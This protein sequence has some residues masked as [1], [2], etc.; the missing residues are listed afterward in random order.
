M[1]A[2]FIG[3]EVSPASFLFLVHAVRM[4]DVAITSARRRSAPERQ[5]CY[6][7]VERCIEKSSEVKFGKRA[8]D[9]SNRLYM[10]R[11]Q[12]YGRRLNGNG[13]INSLPMLDPKGVRRRAEQSEGEEGFLP[14][15][16]YAGEARRL[17]GG[18]STPVRRWG[19]QR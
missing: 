14:S 19:E 3:T 15:Q 10:G 9:V 16:T 17:F 7:V 12:T 8:P 5:Q 2:Y 4:H 18:G 6:H 1:D 11:R 13:K